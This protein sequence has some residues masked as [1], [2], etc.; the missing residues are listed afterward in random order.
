MRDGTEK[1]AGGRMVNIGAE[2]GTLDSG[3]E[4]QGN[5]AFWPLVSQPSLVLS[6][7]SGL[8]P[9]SWGNPSGG[10]A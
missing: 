10:V 5:S 3:R 9:G 8:G 7:K 1:F 6:L 4:I 2:K